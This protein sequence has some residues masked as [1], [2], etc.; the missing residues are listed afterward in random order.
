MRMIAANTGLA[1]PVV[2]NT[3]IPEKESPTP[4]GS[5]GSMHL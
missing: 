5:M 1:G 2:M 4:A 3:D